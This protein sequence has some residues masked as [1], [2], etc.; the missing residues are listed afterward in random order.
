MSA[1]IEVYSVTGL[2]TDGTKISGQQIDPLNAA[3]G[4][5]TR[6][7]YFTVTKGTETDG[8]IYRVIKGL[9]PNAVVVSIKL[10]SSGISGFTSLTIGLYKMG[11]G[12]PAK[13]AACYATGVDLHTAN[14]IGTPVDGMGAITPALLNQPAYLLAGDTEQIKPGG[15]DLALT[16]TTAGTNTGTINGIVEIL[17]PN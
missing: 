5:K 11:I 3:G 6:K 14:T 16:C 10:F 9:D 7:I 17:E 12:R 8:T 2:N 4:V 13:A 15:Y 1:A